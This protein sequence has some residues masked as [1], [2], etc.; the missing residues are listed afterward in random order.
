MD[1]NANKLIDDRQNSGV[2]KNRDVYE[3]ATECRAELHKTLIDMTVKEFAEANSVNVSEVFIGLP[4]ENNL[5]VL[6]C[7]EEETT[8]KG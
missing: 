8:E 3:L 2:I 4:N 5:I 6:T 1:I 7:Y